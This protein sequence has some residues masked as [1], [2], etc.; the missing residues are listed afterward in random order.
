[1]DQWVRDRLADGKI[2]P[3]ATLIEGPGR[4]REE[5]VERLYKLRDNRVLLMSE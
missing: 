4:L 5:L 3:P 1:M 2:G